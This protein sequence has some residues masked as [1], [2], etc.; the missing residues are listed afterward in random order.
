[1][2][3]PIFYRPEPESGPKVVSASL[4]APMNE[5]T[6]LPVRPSWPRRAAAGAWHVPAG[7]GFL[8]RT[9]PL[10]PLALL[11]SLLAVGLGLVGLVVSWYFV[12][13]VEEAFGPSPERVGDALYLLAWITLGLVTLVTGL[14]LGVAL[15]FLL[16]APVLDLLSQRTEARL[17]GHAV[18][19]GRG[20]HFEVVQSLRAGLFFLAAVPVAFLVGLVPFLGPP[21]ATLWGAYA[22]AFALTDGPLTR[23]GLAFGEKLRFQ[24]LWRPETL[25]FGLLGLLTLLVPLA[26]LLVAPALTVGATRLVLELRSLAG[27]EPVGENVGTPGAL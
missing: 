4:L 17:R 1:M 24:S 19:R 3:T 2:P 22:L 6:A 11:P 14:M 25:G 10:W 27:E 9:P 13:R 5:S 23:R 18:D 16:T 21:L 8:L 20:L 7:F 26:N 12:P 15:A